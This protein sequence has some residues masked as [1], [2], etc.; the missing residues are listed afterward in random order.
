MHEYSSGYLRSLGVAE[1]LLRL[2]AQGDVDVDLAAWFTS[3]GPNAWRVGLRPDVRFQGGKA[4]GAKEVVASLERS[5][6]LAPFP[7]NL[8]KGITIDA[9]GDRVVV[10]SPELGSLVNRMR[11]CDACEPWTFGARALMR[12]LAARKIL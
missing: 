5:R 7:A 2:T 8:L 1:G 3:D 10:A 11:P 9:E 12:N 6:A 4:M